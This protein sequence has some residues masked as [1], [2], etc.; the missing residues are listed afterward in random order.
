MNL[1]E[2]FLTGI[3]LSMDAFATSICK[4]LSIKKYNLKTSLIIGLYF[5]IFQSIM[6]LLGY[7]LG[8]TFESLI[9]ELDHWISF[10]VLSIIG[11]NM[12][13]ESLSEESKTNNDKTNIKTML[14]LAIATSIDALAIGITF[15]FLKVNIIKSIIIIGIITFILSF[16][17]TI[18]GNKV[19]TK[20]EKHS[21]LFGGIIL[22]S[23]GLKILLE[24]LD[25]L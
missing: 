17:G 9:T 4:G 20:Y 13:K 3:G 25:I 11:L 16:I 2:I 14:P 23:I 1:I 15:S 12:I 24:H 22:I 8:T 6:P 19:G 21:Q 7:I 18:I 10:L 5:G